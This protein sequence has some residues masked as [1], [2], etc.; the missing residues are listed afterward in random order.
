M[1]LA[2]SYA[3]AYLVP[4]VFQYTLATL[5]RSLKVL[6]FLLG[7]RG[8][9][10][11]GLQLI[12]QTASDGDRAR[13]SAKALLTV[14]EEREK[15]FYRAMKLLDEL[16]A[17]FPKNPLFPLE[18]GWVL[19]L[20]KDWPGAR[21]VYQ[22]ILASREA[23][24]PHYH[25]VRPSLVLLRTG[26]SFLFDHRF[27]EAIDYFNRGLAEPGAPSAIKA[28]LYLRRG[29]A[30]DGLEHR[31]NARADYETTIRLN[32]DKTSKRLAKRFLKK[33][34]RLARLR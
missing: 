29:Q 22:K 5:P 2:P 15:H 6:T 24:A 17:A 28:S 16:E 12:Q 26:E 34:F 4:G 13:W 25:W 27:R 23:N 33:P 14:V 31:T 30:W 1:K 19:L 32:V 10:Q 9:K 3:D 7:Q 20:K 18:R 11:K 21:A 8:S